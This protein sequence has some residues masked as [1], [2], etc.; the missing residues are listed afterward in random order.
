MD[1]RK[2]NSLVVEKMEMHL[3]QLEVLKL[4][5]LY[6]LAKK[7][8]IPYYG[9]MKKKE[10]IFAILRAQAEE[11]GLLFMEG[12]LE[13]LPEG[14]GFLRPINYLPSAEDIYISASQI[15]KFD[16]RSGDL[17]SGKCRPPKENERY[18]GLLHVDAV[19]G[20]SPDTASE[21]LHFPALTPLYPEKK[22]FWKPLL[23]NF[24]QELWICWPPSALVK[25][26]L[27]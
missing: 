12:V 9:Q 17:V 22:S 5:E 20:E 19:N 24:Q 27:L 14:F 25:G 18:F 7:Y 16:L 23:K 15:R 11:G 6:K 26:D 13:V 21:R 1:D 8:Q 2:I 4:T 3:A 10:L